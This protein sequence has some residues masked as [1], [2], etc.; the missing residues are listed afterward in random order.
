M[1]ASPL[2][3]W[4]EER[5]LTQEELAQASGTPLRSV[6]AAEEGR[7]GLEGT[8]QDYLTDQK[9]NVSAMASEQSAFMASQ[10]PG[11]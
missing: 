8:L 4:R 1:P 10:R 5:S 6:K 7:L 3:T 9:V 2:S 11:Q